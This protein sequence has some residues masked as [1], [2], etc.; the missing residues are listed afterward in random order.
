LVLVAISAFGAAVT[1]PALTTL[2]TKAVGR[3]EQGAALGVSQSLAS[4]AQIA[5]P[6]MA[7]SLIEMRALTAY[8]LTASAF[9]V[10]GAV[11]LLVGGTA[12]DAG[13]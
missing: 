6:L 8:G 11:L 7:G 2:I 10:A 3:D 4:V 1:R 12:P 13:A 5:G 9:A